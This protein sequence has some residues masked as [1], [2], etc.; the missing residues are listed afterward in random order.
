M[1]HPGPKVVR[2]DEGKHAICTCGNTGN[3]P[4]CDGSHKGTEFTPEILDVGAEGRPC[5]W[6]TC[7]TTGNQPYC[8]GSHSQ[9]P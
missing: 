2:L 4:F 8:D 9:L 1:P 7:R 3:A 6:C 5:A